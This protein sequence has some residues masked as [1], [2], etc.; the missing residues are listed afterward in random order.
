MQ[1]DSHFSFRSA[2][3]SHFG[4]FMHAMRIVARLLPAVLLT[5]TAFA[6]L[7]NTTAIVAQDGAGGLAYTVPIAI[8]PGTAGMVPTLSLAYS[9]QAGKS[10][11]GVGWGVGG[12]SAI[13]RCPS[14]KAVDGA[15]GGVRL[16]SS[17][18]FCLDGQRLVAINNGT[19]GADGTEYRTDVETFTKIISYGNAGGGPASF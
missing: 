6:G 11:V 12:L 15:V 4:D 13:E 14:S 8:P 16:D 1:T 5:T 7:M 19:Y 10:F 3:S 17:D 2:H 9:S 18:R